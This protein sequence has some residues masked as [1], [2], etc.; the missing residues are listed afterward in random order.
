[1]TTA[2]IH[3]TLHG[4]RRGHERIAG[5]IRLSNESEEVVTRLS[6]LSGSIVS[7]WKFNSYLTGYPLSRD[8][9]FALA[10]TWEDEFATRAGCVLTH[11]LL[12]PL[13]A[14]RSAP[15]PLA[16]SGG[17]ASAKEIQHEDRF[18]KPLSIELSP[19]P[20]PRPVQVPQ[21]LAIEFVMK[22]FGEGRSPIVW[23][24][25]LEP[26]DVSWALIQVLWPKVRE[27]FSWCTASLQPRTL[28]A[29]FLGLQFA[30]SAAYTRF[31]KIPRENFVAVDR[32]S[33]PQ[34]VEPWCE[35]CARWIFSGERPGP[36]DAEISFFGRSLR[37]DPTLMRHLFMA[38][39][40]SE[41]IAASPTA[42][43]GL[44]DV[45]EAI[46]PGATE[47]IEYKSMVFLKSINAAVDA[48]PEEALKSLF[49][50]SE[51]TVNQAYKGI[52]D[53]GHGISANVS[54]LSSDYVR[55]GLLMPERVVSRGDLTNTP[56]FYG[57]VE[58]L[59]RVASESPEKLQCLREFDKIAPHLIAASPRIAAGYLRG[60]SRGAGE[61]NGRDSLLRWIAGFDSHVLQRAMRSELFPE[62]RDDFDAELVERLCQSIPVDEV[63]ACLGALNRSTDGF[64]S[65]RILATLQDLLASR[66]PT[67][68]RTWAVNQKEWPLGVVALVSSTFPC[69]I[70]GFGQLLAFDVE[71][72]TRR[73]DLWTS[74]LAACTASRVPGWFK[75][76]ARQSVDW[77]EHLIADGYAI[78][79][80][81]SALLGRILPELNDVPIASRSD[82]RPI[83][84]SLSQ[85]PFWPSLANLTL[86]NA[87]TTFV[88]GGLTEDVCGA[89]FSESWS[90]RWIEEISRSSLAAV[91]IHP[92]TDMDRRERS[93]RWLSIAPSRLYS[94][95]EFLVPSL[96]SELVSERRFGW[97]QS[98]GNAWAEILHRLENENPGSTTLR[99]CADAIQ[100]GFDHKGE[101]VGAAVA[102][103]FYPVYKAVCESHLAVSKWFRWL[104][105]DRAKELRVGLV[106]AFIDSNWSPG[107]LVLAARQDEQL[108]R[109]LV[110]RVLR[111]K[112]GDAYLASILRDLASRQ[113]PDVKRTADIV[114]ALAANPTF[115]EPWD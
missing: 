108:I 30:P 106:A 4:Y 24:D 1:M 20:S 56:Y 70:S 39:N 58:G 14:W 63:A 91:L 65:P 6:D 46:A 2:T 45:T 53:I 51:R 88:E 66:Y 94:S 68:V 104:D 95:N 113:S 48:C 110:K 62:V 52:A 23:F 107:D 92:V 102:V 64:A 115:Y 29:Q 40:L 55:E 103:A 100:F 57:L 61:E 13:E 87:V 5:S 77:L 105:W 18:Q 3:Q 10:R 36:V 79:Q 44:L 11:T 42:G 84:S 26:E 27:R 69:D 33:V 59:T 67:E 99:V 34:T 60:S 109:K 8:G 49:L 35:P 101:P 82:L 80:S 7:G 90:S 97:T 74:F 43:A 50:I 38:R 21:R 47:A 72:V 41:R 71:I 73:T 28:D 98:I 31:H 76:A 114:R 16:F 85:F 75:E 78:P 96:V 25:C 86:R 32:E 19:S 111:S 22:Y 15:D 9:Y 54:R 93:F 112:N 89:W 81:T 17:L 83:L 37:A 12:I